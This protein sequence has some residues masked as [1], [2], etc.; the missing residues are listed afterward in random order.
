MVEIDWRRYE[1]FTREEFADKLTGRCEMN[2][3]VVDTLSAI[4]AQVGFP[5]VITSGYR[6][7]Q[8]NRDVGGGQ[9]SAHLAGL[10]ADVAVQGERAYGLVRVALRFGVQGIGV[11]HTFVHLD[12]AKS[13]VRDGITLRRRP[14]LWHGR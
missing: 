5:M 6:S 14:M 12:W 1:H 9:Y 10:A 11:Y 13:Y 7:A 8:H 3:G 4:R 2:A